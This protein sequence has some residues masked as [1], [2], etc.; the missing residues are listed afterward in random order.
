MSLVSYLDYGNYSSCDWASSS[1]FLIPSCK[2]KHRWQSQ[3]AL[4]VYSCTLWS[5]S[6]I[7]ACLC[8]LGTNMLHW[9]EFDYFKIPCNVLISLF[10]VH[11]IMV[12]LTQSLHFLGPL[13]TALVF[14]D[15][16]TSLD[17]RYTKFGTN[18]VLSNEIH[19]KWP[20]YQ[21]QKL[22]FKITLAPSHD[23]SGTP[24][25]I[26]LCKKLKAISSELQFFFNISQYIYLFQL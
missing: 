17:Q 8:L 20:L 5:S 21:W 18:P 19:S 23:D 26:V 1:L 4:I 25:Y 10:I 24:R 6:T 16:E 9:Y 11:S 22:A 7:S 12:I 13:P 3:L 15:L 14:S 2:P